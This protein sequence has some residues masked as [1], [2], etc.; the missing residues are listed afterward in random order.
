MIVTQIGV[1]YAITI[2][3]QEI[4][5]RVQSLQEATLMACRM[6]FEQIEG[7]T[8]HEDTDSAI[9]YCCDGETP[10]R[11]RRVIVAAT[12]D[13]QALYVRQWDILRAEAKFGKWQSRVWST[14]G[15][16]EY[17]Q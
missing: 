6:L 13:A 15:Q 16:I 10:G 14:N 12:I 17:N 3:G 1:S 11:M 5:G 4:E 8:F 7:T 2:N 9:I